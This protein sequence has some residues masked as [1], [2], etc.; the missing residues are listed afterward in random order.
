MTTPSKMRLA[1][2]ID[3]VYDDSQHSNDCW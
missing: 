1:Q 2:C 3:E